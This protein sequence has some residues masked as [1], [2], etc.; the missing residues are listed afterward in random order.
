MPRLDRLTA[1]ALIALLMAAISLPAFAYLDPTSGS[2][3]L[4]AILGGF[5]GAAVVLKL[6]WHRI[7]GFFGAK[8]QQH[9]EPP[10]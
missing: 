3:F 7:L 5:A 10:T 6:Y 2:M 4:Q 9:D 8:K 1:I